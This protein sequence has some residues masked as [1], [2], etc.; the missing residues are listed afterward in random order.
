MKPVALNVK[1]GAI[2]H[3][4]HFR[5]VTSNCSVHPKLA[6][7]ERRELK[8][9]TSLETFGIFI[10]VGV[11]FYIIMEILLSILGI[12]HDLGVTIKG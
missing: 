5:N 4:E 7:I 12:E 10:N 6:Q 9:K 2:S 8:I 11:Y 3:L 1:F